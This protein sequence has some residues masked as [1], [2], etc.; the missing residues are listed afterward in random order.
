MFFK[1][2]ELK[3]NEV[4]GNELSQKELESKADSTPLV[5]VSTAPFLLL[6][7]LGLISIY[8]AA[9]SVLMCYSDEQDDL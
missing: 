5:Y 1:C 2:S 8:S 7:A 6:R 3:S 4:Y 9:F